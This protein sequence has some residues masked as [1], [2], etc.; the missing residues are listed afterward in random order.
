MVDQSKSFIMG[1]SLKK[2]FC[3][4]LFIYFF[5]VIKEQRLLSLIAKSS[6]WLRKDIFITVNLLFI[7]QLSF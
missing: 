1:H 6:S 5:F 7:L 2:D 3:Y 4:F